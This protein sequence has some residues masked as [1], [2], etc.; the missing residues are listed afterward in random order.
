MKITKHIIQLFLR[1]LW[2]KFLSIF[3]FKTTMATFS[4]IH[5][6]GETVTTAS[7]ETG[8]ITSVNFPNGS[9]TAPEYEI[10]VQVPEVPEQI[11]PAVPA[12][13]KEVTD[14]LQG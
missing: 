1:S 13:I 2:Q 3:K 11:I 8:V 6:K 12:T 4:S 7:G 14:P 9:G 10:E 5:D